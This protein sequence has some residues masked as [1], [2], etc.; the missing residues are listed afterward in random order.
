SRLPEDL[1]A[2]G[3]ILHLLLSGRTPDAGRALGGQRHSVPAAVRAL[4]AEMLSADP[5]NRPSADEAARRLEAACGVVNAAGAQRSA[6]RRV[7]ARPTP[8]A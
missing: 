7:Q 8:A 6:R 1:Y 5:L 4:V 3:A 2:L